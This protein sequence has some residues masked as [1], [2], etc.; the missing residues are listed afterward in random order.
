MANWSAKGTYIEACDCEAV[1]PCIFLSPPTGESCTVLVGWHVDEGQFDGTDIAGLNAA[2]LAHSPGPMMEGNWKV[3]LY[4]DERASEAQSQ[5]LAGIFSGQA[6]GHLSALGPLIGEV[7]GVRAAKIGFSGSDKQFSVSVDGVGSVEMTVLAGQ[8]GGPVK[9]SGHPLAIAPG[10]P[11]TIARSDKL[12]VNDHGLS[13]DVSG[14][15][16]QFSPFAYAA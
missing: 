5:A 9:V 7:L 11:A 12:T 8:G 14:R 15:S 10:E 3:A 13:L 2:L 1:C 16:A 4:T 6:G